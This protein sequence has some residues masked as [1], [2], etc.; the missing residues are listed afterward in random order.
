MNTP[1]LRVTCICNIIQQRLHELTKII[2]QRQLGLETVQRCQTTFVVICILITLQPP[3]LVPNRTPIQLNASLPVRVAFKRRH[4]RTLGDVVPTRRCH[5]TARPR[6]DNRAGSQPRHQG[7]TAQ[8]LQH[9]LDEVQ[10]KLPYQSRG[11][12]TRVLSRNRHA[13]LT[14]SRP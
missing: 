9:R 11:K 6:R 4:P 2:G 3:Y 5:L 12:T 14:K 7:I 13:R 10:H 1:T 8:A